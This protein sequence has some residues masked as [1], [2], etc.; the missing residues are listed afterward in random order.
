MAIDQGDPHLASTYLDQALAVAR[1]TG[2]RRQLAM[3]RQQRGLLSLAK[4]DLAD[5]RM[6]G[7]E[8]LRIFQKVGDITGVAS[9]E[10]FLGNVALRQREYE[11]ARASYAASLQHQQ[12]WHGVTWIMDSL[13][14]LAAV[15]LGQGQIGRALCLAAATATIG[16]QTGDCLDAA[17]EQTMAAAARRPGRARGC[18]GLGRGRG[19]DA[20]GGHR[21]CPGGT[22]HWVSELRGKAA[23][24]VARRPPYA[25][26]SPEDVARVRKSSAPEFAAGLRSLCDASW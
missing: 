19:N 17:V 9:Q 20:G 14:G 18:R 7:E 3:V 25:P 13:A 23:C 4:G 2:E 22:R 15:A 6:V 5:A 26:G 1:R 12:G 21:L 16:A 11:A 8:S 24:V 10:N